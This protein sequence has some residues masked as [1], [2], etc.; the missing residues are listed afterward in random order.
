MLKPHPPTVQTSH[1]QEVANQK[2]AG[3]KVGGTE[4]ARFKGQ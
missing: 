2:E 1:L 4:T 3:L